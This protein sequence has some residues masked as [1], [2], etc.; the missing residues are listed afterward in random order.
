MSSYLV[1]LLSV[2]FG[3]GLF[4]IIKYNTKIKLFKNGSFYLKSL[5]IL[6]LT[7]SFFWIYFFIQSILYK[8][9]VQNS[10]NCEQY[11][12]FDLGCFV[13]KGVAES[14][15][16][17]SSVV[18]LLTILIIFG[19]FIKGFIVR[20][21]CKCLMLQHT[22]GNKKM[23]FFTIMLSFLLFIMVIFSMVMLVLSSGF[24]VSYT[25]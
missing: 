2:F 17:Y 14:Y 24:K 21:K 22:S 11:N 25:E 4:W 13:E 9:I 10:P 18:L 15:N 16:T 7:N 1:F 19:I 20:K 12:E 8:R 23:I 6:I 5:F 3:I